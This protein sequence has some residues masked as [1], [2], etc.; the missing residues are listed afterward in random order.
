MLGVRLLRRDSL[1]SFLL[2]FRPRLVLVR[3]GF[4]FSSLR[5]GLPVVHH[6][7][8]PTRIN[9]S[10]CTA[11]SCSIP[12]CAIGGIRSF[13][14]NRSV[15]PSAK[16]KVTAA[17][18]AS[19]RTATISAAPITWSGCASGERPIRATGNGPRGRPV[20][21]KISSQP[22]LLRHNQFLPRHL[23]HRYKISSPCKILCWL[24][25]SLI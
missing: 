16:L 9:K 21:Y 1:N 17:G 7:E 2:L 24:E 6:A 19:Q 15:A 20:R 25:L 10:V 3:V 18:Y 13:A 11:K 22:K 14:P 12:I 4:F 23:Q 8:W 5:A